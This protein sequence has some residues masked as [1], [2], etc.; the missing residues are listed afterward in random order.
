MRRR[1]EF[2]MEQMRQVQLR[3]VRR[4]LGTY[5][6]AQRFSWE[7]YGLCLVQ[8]IPAHVIQQKSAE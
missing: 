7:R 5:R 1:I 8:T 2:H 6:S 3:G 4:I